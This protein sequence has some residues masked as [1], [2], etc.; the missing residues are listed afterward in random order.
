MDRRFRAGHPWVY[1]NELMESPKGLMPGAP[2]ELHDPSGKFLARGYGN[3]QSLISFRALSRDPQLT[4]PFSTQRLTQVLIRAGKLRAGVG[5]G[6]VSHRLC[7]GEADGIPGL[8]IDRFVIPSGQ[9]FVIQAHTAGADQLVP[10]I[11]ASLEAYVQ[12]GAVS[13][14]WNKTAIVLRND[15]GV[16]KLEG[17]KEE[18]PRILKDLPGTQLDST[19]IL[20]KASLGGDP[21]PFYV[22]LLQGQKTGFFLDQAANIQLA[23]LRLKNL[24]TS[25]VRILD[26]CCY[27]G[28][29]STQ[30]ARAFREAGIQTEV[31]AVDASSQ[32]LD[33]ARR[34]IAAQGAT[35]ETLKA[36]VLKDLGQLKDRSFDLVISD[37]PALIKSRKDIPPGTHAYLQL[38]TQVFRL[39]KSGGGVVCCSCS[40]LLEEESLTQVL[41]KAAIRNQTQVQWIG[42]G[43]QSPDHPMLTEFPEGRYLKGWIGRI[44]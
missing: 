7:F 28:Q 11:L 20:V 12:S 19:Q 17:L 22:D 21:V 30:F 14:A 8:V 10:R 31:V 40:A 29:W 42:R 4:D 34:N 9:V 43:S 27:V 1:S 36:D 13:V 5:L 24:F 35:C 37:P 38:S 16:R 32:A 44:L 2:V 6:D 25:K 26:L 3:P 39:V 23:I 15:L 33:L 41:T 18:E